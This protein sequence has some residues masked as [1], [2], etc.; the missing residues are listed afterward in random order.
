MRVKFRFG[1]LALGIKGQFATMIVDDGTTTDSPMDLSRQ[2]PNIRELTIASVD[3]S[4]PRLVNAVHTDWVDIPERHR[5]FLI[6][7]EGCRMEV[8]LTGWVTGFS[9]ARVEVTL[10]SKN[11][12]SKTAEF[13]HNV[14]CYGIS[15]GSLSVEGEVQMN[16]TETRVRKAREGLHRRMQTQR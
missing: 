16:G 10:W 5:D 9:Q 7:A 3:A 14:Q 6:N 13:S 8:K 1:G 12:D 15:A 4:L 2:I 11:G